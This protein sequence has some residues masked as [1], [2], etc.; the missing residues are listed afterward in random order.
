MVPNCGF[1]FS[2]RGKCEW[3]LTL[4]EEMAHLEKC[5]LISQIDEIIHVMVTNN[6]GVND[7]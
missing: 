2:K 3:N 7:I 1:I 4:I 5:Y 6:E